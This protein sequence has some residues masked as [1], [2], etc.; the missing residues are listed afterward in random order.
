MK[1]KQSKKRSLST[2]SQL[3]KMSCVEETRTHSRNTVTSK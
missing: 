3:L 2:I 1:R